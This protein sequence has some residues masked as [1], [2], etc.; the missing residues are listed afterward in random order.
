MQTTFSAYKTSVTVT[1]NGTAYAL[2]LDTVDHSAN[3]DIL[4]SIGVNAISTDADSMDVEYI[5]SGWET[6]NDP[7]VLDDLFQ[8]RITQTKDSLSAEITNLRT[9]ISLYLRSYKDANNNIEGVELGR[10]DTNTVSRIVPG[11]FQVWAPN[12]SGQMV[13][14]ASLGNRESQIGRL[15]IY[16]TADGGTAFNVM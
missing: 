4:P 11:A 9:D 16:Q 2:P 6:V 15:R 7:D 1:H 5:C 14:T 3:I 13:K 12:D 8:S 10:T